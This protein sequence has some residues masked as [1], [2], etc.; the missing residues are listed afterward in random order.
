MG[1]IE[2]SF[3]EFRG[4]IYNEI[5]YYFEETTVGGEKAFET[6][7]GKNYRLQILT[8]I[9]VNRDVVREEGE[10]A[11]RVQLVDPSGNP[12][13]TTPHTK[14]TPGYRDRVSRKV[15]EIAN[16]PECGDERKVSDGEYG[17]YMFCVS[18]TCEHTESL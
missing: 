14:R 18:E 16:C 6:N 15:K 1:T 11:I 2:I 3:N 13:K 12:V 9:P 4:F 17:P 8:S 7:M 5:P 10:D